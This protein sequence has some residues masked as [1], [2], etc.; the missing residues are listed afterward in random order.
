MNRRIF[1]LAFAAAMALGCAAQYE[2]PNVARAE[3][4]M[5]FVVA[6][7]ADSL[8]AY[9]AD[10]VLSM[11]KEG[12][13]EGVLAKVEAQVGKY[14][15]HGAWEVQTVMGQ[16]AYV[17]MMQFERGELAMLIVFNGAGRMLGI[18][19]LPPEAVKKG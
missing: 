12:S 6:N 15:G 17:S 7:Q 19:M 2:D 18:Q 4:M 8:Y 3:R 9:M 13:F 5:G 16:K 1:S 11:V 10:E 14:K